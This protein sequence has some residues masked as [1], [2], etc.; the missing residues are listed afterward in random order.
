MPTLASSPP[1][2]LLCFSPRVL[3][4]AQQPGVRGCCFERRPR[5]G[6]GSQPHLMALQQPS[7]RFHS[8]S[9][10]ET[11]E[12]KQRCAA[13][14]CSPLRHAARV[15][16]RKGAPSSGH[17]LALPASQRGPSICCCCFATFLPRDGLGSFQAESR[18]DK[19]ATAGGLEEEQSASVTMNAS[20][21]VLWRPGGS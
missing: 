12:E 16:R 13:G 17:P 18:R 6:L 2:V 15:G 20:Q 4:H 1:E 5:E 11:Q 9:S 21:V 3:P 7:S 19:G 14:A 10:A 8:H